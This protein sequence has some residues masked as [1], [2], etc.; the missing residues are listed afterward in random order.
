MQSISSYPTI[1]KQVSEKGNPILP[2]YGRGCCNRG[3]I[4]F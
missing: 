4:C 2:C 3:C 1:R